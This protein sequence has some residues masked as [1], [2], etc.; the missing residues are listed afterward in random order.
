MAVVA[1]DVLDQALGG[2]LAQLGRE[3]V[4]VQREEIGGLRVAL[5]RGVVAHV[6]VVERRHDL[7]PQ[8]LVVLGTVGSAQRAPQLG[9]ELGVVGPVGRREEVARRLLA[10]REPVAVVVA[11]PRRPQHV[12]VVAQEIR[13]VALHRV[14]VAL[15]EAEIA[16]AAPGDPRHDHAGV[17]PG[18]RAVALEHQPRRHVGVRAVGRLR[19]ED[20]VAPL[21]DEGADV[22]VQRRGGEEDL[23]IGEPAQALVALRAVGGNGDEVAA[24]APVDVAPELVDQ[25]VRALEPSGAR[26][27]GVH[28]AARDRLRARLAGEAAHL[29]VAEAV[30]GEARLVDLGAAAAGARTCPPAARRAGSPHTASRRARSSRRSAAGP[31]CRARPPPRGGR[32]RPCSGRGRRRARPALAR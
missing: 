22:H 4:H 10:D 27:V 28:D 23:R 30:E 24:L 1:L 17:G 13:H 15:D 11:A 25:L 19:V 9:H 12:R 32:G 26:R 14:P 3:Q 5:D 2:A 21:G 16:V 7:R 6:R 20:V 8:A 29:D 31:P 18:R